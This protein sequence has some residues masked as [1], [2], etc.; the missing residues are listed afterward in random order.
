MTPRVM[1]TVL[2]VNCCDHRLQAAMTERVNRILALISQL[3]AESGIPPLLFGGV[4][5]KVRAERCVKHIFHRATNTFRCFFMSVMPR[6]GLA[7]W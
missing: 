3:F 2:I 4:K 6:I 5:R 1:S 7:A